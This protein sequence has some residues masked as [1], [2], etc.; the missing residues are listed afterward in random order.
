[1]GGVYAG[2]HPHGAVGTPNAF[3][4]RTT[5]PFGNFAA[6][7][8][9]AGLGMVNGH[10]GSGAG[11]AQGGRL[12]MGETEGGMEGGI[13]TTG[14]PTAMGAS[15]VALRRPLSVLFPFADYSYLYPFG[16]PG[17][18]G[19]YPDY[20]YLNSYLPAQSSYGVPYAR[21]PVNDYSTAYGSNAVEA[22]TVYGSSNS[23]SAGGYRAANDGEAYAADG[24]PV[25][26]R[27]FFRCGRRVS[28]G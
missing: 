11:L 26:E 12:G 6:T 8:H 28:E 19:S 2:P 5:Q 7:S 21:R 9:G 25:G 20:S 24:A 27:Y 3:S 22:G 13:V 17:Y 18:L 14:I 10:P 16:Y 1:M 4:G 23:V 15:T